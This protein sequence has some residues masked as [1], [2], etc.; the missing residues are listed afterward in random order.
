MTVSIF[1]VNDLKSE[2]EVEGTL[3]INMVGN[4][5]YVYFYPNP[6]ED[7]NKYQF[8]KFASAPE[9]IKELFEL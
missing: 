9:E 8:G 2:I 7:G 3:R 5:Y 1:L 6:F 4:S